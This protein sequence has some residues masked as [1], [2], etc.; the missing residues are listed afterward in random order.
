MLFFF[1]F[2]SRAKQIVREVVKPREREREGGEKKRTL[3]K[4]QNR[5]MGNC[6]G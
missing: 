5:G 4:V 3:K 2:I 6:V 1:L